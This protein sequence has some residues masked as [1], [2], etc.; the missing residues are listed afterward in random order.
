MNFLK[1]LI[2][3][4]T[5]L[6][7]ISDYLISFYGFNFE[8]EY[9]IIKL[10]KKKNPTIVDIGGNRGES[11]KNFL[12]YKR[13]SKIF[14]FEPK[15]N[16]FNHIKKKYKEKNIKIFNYGIGSNSKNLILYTP[17]IY[18]YQFSGLSSTNPSN[19]KFRLNF[20][21]KN[22]NKKFRFIKEEIKL[23]KLDELN[24]KPDLIKIDTE[25]SELDVI[26]SSLKTIKKYA[27]ILIIEFNHNNFFSIQQK[28]F[29]IGYVSY[30]LKNKNLNTTNNKVLKKIKKEANLTNIIFIKNKLLYENKT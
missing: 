13:L 5:F 26:N 28:L 10:V 3:K 18:N 16:S 25:G 2:K 9:R 23:K 1:N 4:N 21:F 17:K 12:R 6:T 15:K 30:I 7:I 19:L 11:I 24:L 27:P 29:K 8:K 20:F 22:I 14:C